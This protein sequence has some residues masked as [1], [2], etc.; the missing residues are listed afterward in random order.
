MADIVDSLTRTRMMAGIRSANTAP[1]LSLRKLLHGHGYRYRL[2]SK[3]L[4]GKPD[5]VF[6]KYRAIIFVHGCFWHGHG[7]PAFRL[8]STNRQF[9]ESKI[10]GNRKRDHSQRMQ[11]T[12]MGWKNKNIWECEI[13]QAMKK[14]SMDKLAEKIGIWLKS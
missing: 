4:P 14:N 6:P 10:Q 3:N 13:R 12:K 7:C 8:P 5:L 11:L 2:H 1:E 9:W